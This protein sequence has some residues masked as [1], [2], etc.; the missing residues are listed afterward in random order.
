MSFGFCHSTALTNT[1]R[2]SLPALLNR[3]RYGTSSTSFNF[4]YSNCQK[5]VIEAGAVPIFVE[6][7]SSHEADVREQAVWALGNI[8]GDSPACRDFVLQAGA[9][10][11]LLALLG[12]SRKLSMLRNATWVSPDCPHAF[13]PIGRLT[14]FADS[15]KFL[16]RKGASMLAT[17]SSPYCSSPTHFL[18]CQSYCSTLSCSTLPFQSPLFQMNANNRNR[19]W[20]LT[21]HRR[22]SLIGRLSSPLSLFSPNLCTALMT[23]CL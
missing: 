23:R 15:L 19:P 14:I 17:R 8:A 12:D 5:V 7:L 4:I 3:L 20:I 10:R 1:S 21:L 13:F 11:P 9:L 18:L 2:T 16:S 22:H 6:L